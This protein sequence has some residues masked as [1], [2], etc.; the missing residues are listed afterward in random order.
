M[1][2]GVVKSALLKQNHTEIRVRHPAF[3]V[4]REGGAPKRFNVDVCCGLPP[5]QRP[6]ACYHQ[7]RS[8]YDGNAVPRK[9]F[10]QTDYA[11]TRKSDWS[12]ASQI[13]IMICHERVAKR[14]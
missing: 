7:Q 9:F 1:N 10:A 6:Q 11:R 3:G 13:L 4:S 12:D 5:R 2:D 8:A 14:K